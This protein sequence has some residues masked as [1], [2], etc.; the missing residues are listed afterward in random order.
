MSKKRPS[1]ILP[2]A[3][4]FYVEE[5]TRSSKAPGVAL[6]HKRKVQDS[7]GENLGNLHKTTYPHYLSFFRTFRYTNSYIALLCACWCTSVTKN[8]V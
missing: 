1:A 6:H 2:P 5:S 8:I 3:L 4:F 7:T